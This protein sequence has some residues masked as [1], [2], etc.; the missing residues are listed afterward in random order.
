M[1]NHPQ[2]AEPAPGA[3][4]WRLTDGL[5]EKL[6]E[7]RAR[8]LDILW[9]E[10]CHADLTSLV[11]EGGD[12]AVRL[13][14]DPGVDRAWYGDVEI[15]HTT[16]RAMTWVFVRGEDPS[17]EVSAHIVSAPQPVDTDDPDQA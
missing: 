12:T 7:L 5:D 4:P 17:G 6:A 8:G 3:T 9:I 1:A 14:P 11:I 10:A 13:D 2:R 15:R 16:L